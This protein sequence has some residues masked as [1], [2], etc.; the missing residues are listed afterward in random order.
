MSNKKTSFANEIVV[1]VK[2]LVVLLAITFAIGVVVDFFL[3]NENSFL[4][5][6]L[7]IDGITR[8]SIVVA[9]CYIVGSAVYRRLTERDATL[10]D[11]AIIDF[12]EY[13][14]VIAKK[15]I[16]K[17]TISYKGSAE[18]ELLECGNV[19]KNSAHIVT[20]EQVFEIYGRVKKKQADI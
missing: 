10:D 16:K 18:G 4:S 2:M 14:L 17:M 12:L 8:V 5:V 11:V 20:G 6:L 3:S 7:I 19:S 1:I 13:K 15:S 9:I